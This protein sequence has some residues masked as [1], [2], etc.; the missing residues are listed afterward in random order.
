MNAQ[1]VVDWIHSNREVKTREETLLEDLDQEQVD[2]LLARTGADPDE[3]LILCR[4]PSTAC[5]HCDTDHSKPYLEY[6][7]VTD[8]AERV[9]PE[10]SD[11]VP[12][13]TQ[14]VLLQA[15]SSRGGGLERYF[16]E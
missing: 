10:L 4:H 2:R 9:V 1:D 3:D 7:P 6:Q 5:P 12:P 16:R 15:A 11:N 14:S 8:L 13:L